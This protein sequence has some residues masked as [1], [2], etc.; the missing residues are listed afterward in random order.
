MT[1]SLE[2]IHKFMHPQSIIIDDPER[3]DTYFVAALRSKAMDIGRGI[4][5]LPSNAVENMMWLTHLDS[6]SLAGELHRF[7]DN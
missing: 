3:E 1:A 5:E 6:G 4:I 7:P 2:H